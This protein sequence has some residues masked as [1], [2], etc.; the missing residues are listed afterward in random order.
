MWGISVAESISNF[1]EVVFGLEGTLSFYY[2]NL[3]AGQY[4]LG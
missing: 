3:M 4:A 2:T 1:E